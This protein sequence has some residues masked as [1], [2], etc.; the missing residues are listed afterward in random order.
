MY[1]GHIDEPYGQID[2]AKVGAEVLLLIGHLSQD[3]TA[4]GMKT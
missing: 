4:Y 3:T 1:A 2:Q